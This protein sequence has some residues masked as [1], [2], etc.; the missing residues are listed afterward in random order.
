MV[1][2]KTLVETAVAQYSSDPEFRAF[3][4]RVRAG[5]L[6]RFHTVVSVEDFMAY[7]VQPE[8]PVAVVI[9]RKWNC[10]VAT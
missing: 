9:Y 7:E 4:D 2:N 3:V 1:S 6:S 8:L 5:L 10:L